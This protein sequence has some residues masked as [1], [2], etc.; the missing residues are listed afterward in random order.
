MNKLII[1]T[2]C[3]FSSVLGASNDA[4]DAVNVRDNIT[5][6]LQ[7]LEAGLNQQQ[8]I[9]ADIFAPD[10]VITLHH[11]VT[12]KG[13]PSIRSYMQQLLHGDG[14]VLTK[15][16][17]RIQTDLTWVVSPSVVIVHGTSL[18][19]FAFSDGLAFELTSHW[20]MTLIPVESSWKIQS[21]QV[22]ENLF[23]NPLLA[24]A[25][26]GMEF[27][28]IAGFILGLV[29]SWIFYRAVRRQSMLR[30]S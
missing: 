11:G 25:S 22:A 16:Q 8:G 1:F 26:K 23:E 27:T 21:L 4:A 12:L 18:D 20:S 10:I 14:V 15:F 28:G 24:S 7:Q 6:V 5:H 13:W 19:N 17:S 2:L 3:L 9:S 29:A 30:Y